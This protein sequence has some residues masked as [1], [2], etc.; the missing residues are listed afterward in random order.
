MGPGAPSADTRCG[1]TGGSAR[2]AAGAYGFNSEA[3]SARYRPMAGGGGSLRGLSG[4][5]SGSPSSPPSVYRAARPAGG[6]RGPPRPLRG[7]GPTPTSPRRKGEGEGHK[8][9]AGKKPSGE[10]AHDTGNP[11]AG[12]PPSRPV[13]WE[14]G[15]R[16]EGVKPSAP[17]TSTRQRGE[18]ERHAVRRAGAKPAKPRH[19][20]R[21]PIGRA[22]RGGAQ[23]G[24]FAH[25]LEGVGTPAGIGTGAHAGEE[26]GHDCRAAAVRRGRQAGPPT[27]PPPPA[28][29][30]A[31]QAPKGGG[32]RTGRLR[33]T[34]P[35]T[36]R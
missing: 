14:P 19:G 2:S 17:K 31:V 23:C 27:N 36:R 6:G 8:E 32:P 18:G 7:K 13:P 9:Q 29:R 15:R 3:G 22:A 5:R 30:A 11:K 26:R 1:F 24:F 21:G 10:P 4:S 33:A 25:T 16:G 35:Q 28:R 34:A 20:T 12:N